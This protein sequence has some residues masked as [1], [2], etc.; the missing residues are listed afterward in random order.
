MR[1]VILDRKLGLA[2]GHGSVYSPPTSSKQIRV[3]CQAPLTCKLI[4]FVTAVN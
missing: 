2:A 3:P 1:A 4:E